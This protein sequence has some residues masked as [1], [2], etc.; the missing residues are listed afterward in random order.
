MMK[1]DILQGPLPPR[2]GL[3]FDFEGERNL[4]NACLRSVWFHGAIVDINPEATAD[5]WP[6]LGEKQKQVLTLNSVGLLREETGTA[7]NIAPDTVKS[8]LQV[9]YRKLDVTGQNAGGL[10]VGRCFD[11]GIFVV[12]QGIEV[13]SKN[14][15]HAHL[16]DFI[17]QGGVYPAFRRLNGEK[18][19]ARRFASRAFK[20]FNVASQN[21]LAFLAHVA[22]WLPVQKEVEMAG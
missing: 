21:G 10:A 6:P 14:P 8:H 20:R 9:A 22:G 11:T 12:R 5:G 13:D 3:K 4:D 1:T 2:V 17:A 16:A 7:L 18:I 15:D 19:N